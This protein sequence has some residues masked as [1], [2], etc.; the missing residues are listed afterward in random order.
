VS[1]SAWRA[2]CCATTPPLEEELIV[3]WFLTRKGAEMQMNAHEKDKDPPLSAAGWIA[4]VVPAG[5]FF[6]ALWYAA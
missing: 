6:V 2:S 1:K 3:S 4:L 5:F